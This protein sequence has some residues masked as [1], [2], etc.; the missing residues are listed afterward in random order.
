MVNDIVFR[1]FNKETDESI[2]ADIW[3]EGPKGTYAERML[4]FGGYWDYA[5]RAYEQRL[6]KENGECQIVNVA[7]LIDDKLEGV[8]IVGIA[9]N[10]AKI[11]AL[12]VN[13]DTEYRGIG[14]DFKETL[15]NNPQKLGITLP[16]SK[17]TANI[18]KDN[19]KSINMFTSRNR[20]VDNQFCLEDIMDD[21][22][23][24]VF[25]CDRKNCAL[26]TK[27][28]ILQEYF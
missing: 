8:M 27:N 2:V 7:G 6:K 28:E 19:K 10:E 5:A 20:G 13:P 22:N 16:F 21:G 18:F 25:S 9:N 4:S 24:L 14:G 23:L 15:L 1:K 26:E 12:F 11:Y 3:F 17:V